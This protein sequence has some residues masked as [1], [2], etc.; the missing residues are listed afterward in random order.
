MFA[1]QYNQHHQRK[2]QSQTPNFIDSFYIYDICIQCVLVLCCIILEYLMF[3]AKQKNKGIYIED[4]SLEISN[5]P[6]LP[7]YILE[8]K[9]QQYL[10]TE[11]KK[12]VSQEENILFDIDINSSQQTYFTDVL[13]QQLQNIKE[14]FSDLVLGDDKQYHSQCRKQIEQLETAMQEIVIE[15]PTM[16]T[17]W[18]TLTTRKQKYLLY[19]MLQQ[20]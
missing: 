20:Q 4:F 15:K 13:S 1:E 10:Q 8:S 3:K 11:I 6:L 7:S 17:A 12:Q 16:N 2:G 14:I 5:L 19:R 18:V 9:L